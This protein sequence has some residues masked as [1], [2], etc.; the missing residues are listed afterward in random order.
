MAGEDSPRIVVGVDGSEPSKEALR[1]A[2]RQAELVGGSLDAVVAWE[3]P[4]S[5]YGWVPEID[6]AKF[7]EQ[8][9]ATF[10]GTL[11]EV[12]GSEPTVEVRRHVR[13]GDPATVL[14]DVANGAELLVVGNRGHGA[15]I[16]ALLG[17]VSFRCVHHATCPVVVVHAGGDRDA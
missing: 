3:Y 10:A 12:L 2:A 8:S 14:L 7:H 15:F 16:G 9:D 4:P 11:K 5:Y 1:W 6:V 17:S 13:E